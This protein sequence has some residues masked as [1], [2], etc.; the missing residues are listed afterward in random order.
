MPGTLYS[1]RQVH[2]LRQRH[3]SISR[4][5]LFDTAVSEP[6]GPNPGAI[7]DLE[8]FVRKSRPA[9]LFF[10]EGVVGMEMPC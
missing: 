2:L 5:G 4:M 7:F 3:L 1:P 8:D 6:N 10:G 9:F